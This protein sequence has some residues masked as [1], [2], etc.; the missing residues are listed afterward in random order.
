MIN[1]DEKRERVVQMLC[2]AVMAVEPL[3]D[4]VTDRY[5]CPFCLSE[6]CMRRA[7]TRHAVLTAIVHNDGCA[8]LLA[9]D[10]YVKKVKGA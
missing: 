6:D 8:F 2:N 10:L 1:H 7:I 9:E 5:S 3:Y 4:D